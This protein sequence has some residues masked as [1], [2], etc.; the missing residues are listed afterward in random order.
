MP[1]AILPPEGNLAANVIYWDLDP[2]VP[3]ANAKFLELYYSVTDRLE[4]DTISVWPEGSVIDSGTA[5]NL[6]YKVCEQIPKARPTVVVGAMN[7]LGDEDY[8]LVDNSASPYI[9]TA[10]DAVVPKGGPPS[11]KNPAIRLHLGYG[12]KEHDDDF[13]GG[14]QAQVCPWGGFAILNY[15]GDPAYMATAIAANPKGLEATL[16]TKA[17]SWFARVGYQWDLSK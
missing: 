12:T 8:G 2:P 1:I 4:V 17:G 11:L 7:L 15:Q 6:A 14:V 3:A 9:V 13:F 16:G 5:V 10:Y